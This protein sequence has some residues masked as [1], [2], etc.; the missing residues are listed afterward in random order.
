MQALKIDAD[1]LATELREAITAKTIRLPSL[2]DVAM[3][4]K[5]AV[6]GECSAQE[7]AELV[8]QDI[9]L[10]GR[11]VQVANSPLYR[12][13][14][15]VESIQVAVTRLGTRLVKN[16]VIGLAMKQ[17]FKTSSKVLSQYFREVWED[18]VGVAAVSRILAD[19]IPGIDPEEAMLAGLLHNIGALPILA[20]L[21]QADTGNIDAHTVHQ[22]LSELA[23]E[24]GTRILNSWQLPDGLSAVPEA[25]HVLNRDSGPQID[26]VDI[27]L[28][29]RLQYLVSAGLMDV[30]PELS[31]IPALAKLGIHFE[32]I[33]LGD[34]S[35]SAWATQLRDTLA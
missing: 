24:T 6:E 17:M 12:G 31:N 28:S 22:L 32:T 19:G 8:A 5:K 23:P 9:A 25:C 11:L 26:Y 1:D 10:T 30:T 27:V 16:L 34:E 3:R 33:V 29:A 18:S 13:V 21:D 20:L 35:N 14:G 2:P 7:I 4:V 15:E